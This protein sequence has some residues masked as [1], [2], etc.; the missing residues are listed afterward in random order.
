MDTEFSEWIQRFGFTDKEVETYDAILEHGPATA[1]EIADETEVSKR[2]VYNIA[3]ELER[4]EF[5]VIN[6]FVNRRGSNPPN[7][8]ESIG[9]C[10]GKPSR[11]TRR[12]N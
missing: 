3:G 11:C 4:R 9:R 1:S 8:T 6:D 10:D 2:H 7:P 5:V 12:S